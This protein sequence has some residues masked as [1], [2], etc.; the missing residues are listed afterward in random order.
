MRKYLTIDLATRDIKSEELSGEALARAG[1]Y[2]I[3]KTLV[4]R[5][6]ANIDPLG[7]ENP[8]IFS[9][10]P[11]A[12]TNFSNAN[13]ISVGCKS[14]LTGGVKE[15][16]G[17]GTMAFAMAQIGIAWITLENQSDDWVVIRIPLEGDITFEDATPYLGKG[18]FETAGML[19][20]KYGDK[21]SLGICSPV[22]E[23]GGLISGIVFTDPE[24]RPTRISAR[25]GVGAVMGSKKV[26]AIVCDKHKMPDFHERKKLMQSIKTY[27]GMIKD[28]GRRRDQPPGWPAGAQFF[29]WAVG[30]HGQGTPEDGRRLH[31]RTEP[32]T[33]RRNHPC[34]HARLHDQMLQRLCR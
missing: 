13:R 14:P 33:R 21:V 2:L 22:G 8:L 20:E 5:D 25:G 3:A 27:G 23:Y 7:P 15:S 32:G 31:P 6:L 16:N 12:G 34:L 17:G 1:R 19:F 26:K 30:R 24:G 18:V 10:G 9:A 29:I 28:S 11:F 4:D